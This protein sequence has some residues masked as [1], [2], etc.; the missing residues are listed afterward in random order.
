MKITLTIM[1][2]IA[3]IGA[4]LERLYL[5]EQSAC[6]TQLRGFLLPK[7]SQ[8]SAGSDFVCGL[9]TGGSMTCWGGNRYGQAMPPAGTFTQ[10]S[11]GWNSSS[12]EVTENSACGLR[13]NGSLVCWGGNYFGD[14]PSG[15]FIQVS[16]GAGNI[17]GVR[18]GGRVVCWGRST[19]GSGWKV[20]S[21]RFTQVSINENYDC[22]LRTSGGLACWGSG[23]DV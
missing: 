7:F 19:D 15:R 21:G 14:P 4:R 1:S 12:S 17:C 11:A 13:A 20:P 9:R 8:I 10:V 2:A 6:Y 16:T 18:A 5:G 3:V 23:G 22:G